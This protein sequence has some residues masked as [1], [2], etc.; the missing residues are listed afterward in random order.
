MARTG[1]SSL[2]TR[3]VPADDPCAIIVADSFCHSLE[4][5]PM[6]YT[7]KQFDDETIRIDEDEYA[8][9]TFT[10]CRIVFTGAGPARFERCTFDRCEWVFAGAAETTLLYLRSLYSGIEPG[11]QEL[12]EALFESIRKGGVGQGVLDPAMSPVLR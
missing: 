7:F 8:D 1:L 11:G 9:C 12:V 2:D 3:A 10:K 4:E 5:S 6:R